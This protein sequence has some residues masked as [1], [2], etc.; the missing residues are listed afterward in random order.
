MPCKGYPAAGQQQRSNKAVVTTMFPHENQWTLELPSG[1]V[2][3][4][5]EPSS[6][7]V[8]ISYLQNPGS[9]S[10]T[11]HSVLVG[12][13]TYEFGGG[14]LLASPAHKF[15]LLHTYSGQCYERAH[16]CRLRPDFVYLFEDGAE[17]MCTNYLF[18]DRQELLF[19]VR[20]ITSWNS[21]SDW[22]DAA[23]SNGWISPKEQGDPH[24]RFSLQYATI[25]QWN[26]QTCHKISCELC[27]DFSVGY[28][29]QMPEPN[30]ATCMDLHTRL[31]HTHLWLQMPWGPLSIPLPLRASIRV[32]LSPNNP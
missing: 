1:D 12:D 2:L 23:Y 8:E 25:T 22:L 17:G 24:A 14:S 21:G 26:L 27:L 10:E 32:Q 30:G 20:P 11:K 31:T 7:P 13:S 6:R 3:S 28:L 4:C 19:I 9:L 16:V 18:C 29:L 5:S 15:A